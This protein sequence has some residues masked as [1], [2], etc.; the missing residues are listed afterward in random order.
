ML[1]VTLKLQ[2]REA[3]M[4]RYPTNMEIRHSGKPRQYKSNIYPLIP[5]DITDI[6]LISNAGDRLDILAYKYYED[7]TLWWII[8]TA[9]GLGKSGMMVPP[10]LQLRIPQD[11]SEAQELYMALQESR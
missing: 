2:E 9:N 7:Q 4:I 1:R 3:L 11:P 6:Y 10:G 5:R 8:A